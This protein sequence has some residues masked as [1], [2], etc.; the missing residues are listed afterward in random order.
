MLQ[1]LIKRLFFYGTEAWIFKQKYVDVLSVFEGN[2]FRIVSGV[3]ESVFIFGRRQ[4][5]SN[6]YHAK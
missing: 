2:I 6:A 4:Q 3:E 1:R 5:T